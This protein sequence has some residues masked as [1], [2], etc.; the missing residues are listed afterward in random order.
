MIM[1][2]AVPPII[3]PMWLT[4]FDQ[5]MPEGRRFPYKHLPRLGTRVS[6]TFGQ[7]IPMERIQQAIEISSGDQVLSS[8]PNTSKDCRPF[9]P[10]Q[11]SGNVDRETL[12]VLRI[13][14]EITRVVQDEVERLGRL[15]SGDSLCT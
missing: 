2:A 8:F 9:V 12:D 13:R 6:V 11:K 10:S 4:G 14:A 15:I 3:I 1:E 5:L 7:P